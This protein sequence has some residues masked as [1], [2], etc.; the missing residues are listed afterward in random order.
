M[1]SFP[2]EK[3]EYA[4][5]SNKDYEYL[6][7]GTMG[8]MGSARAMNSEG[9]N[10]IGYTSGGPKV[11]ENLESELR[12][13]FIRKVYGILTLQLFLT[14]GVS[15]FTVL[16]EPATRFVLANV[17]TVYL[18]FAFSIG[19]LIAL[20]CY[21]QSYPLNTYLL[22]AW[23]LVEAYT[24]GVVCASY[25]TQGQGMVVVQ[26][27]GLTMA[28]FLGLTL[29]TFQTKIDFSFLVG[30]V[31]PSSL[32]NQQ[33]FRYILVPSQSRFGYFLATVWFGCVS[34]ARRGSV[35]GVKG[36]GP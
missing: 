18:G 1:T 30:G 11:R 33:C 7:A 17:W 3:E 14:F 20:M 12:K 26:A 29:F 2:H 34:V 32:A 24:I 5:S 10:D 22:G 35:G 28:V 36:S 15:A 27:A 23:T 31:W 25:F 13:G 21:R 8:M 19:L 9:Y 4:R 16:Y 6:E